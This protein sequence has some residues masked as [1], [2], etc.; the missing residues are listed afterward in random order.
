MARFA[1]IPVFL[2]SLFLLIGCGQPKDFEIVHENG[3]TILKKYTGSG[4]VEN[5]TIPEGVTVIG[6][7][8]F[9]DFFSLSSV[10]IPQ[11]VTKIGER[12]FASCR[13]LKSVEIPESVTEI[14][15]MAFINC[16]SLTT[17]V[18]PEGVM[19]IGNLAFNG[20]ISLTS[21]EIPESVK[22][23]EGS[24]LCECPNLTIYAPKGSKAEEYA[25]RNGI[26][27]EAK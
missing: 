10:V 12:A 18:I 7:G 25:K 14:G 9:S 23:I 27:F 13:S 20:N 4:S 3:Q 1:L 21:V 2:F 6:D 24:A 22:E 17:L 8:A 11:G 19:K 5:V 26:P 16:N 15:Y